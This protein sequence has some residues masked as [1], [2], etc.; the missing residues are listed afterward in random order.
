MGFE[1]SR[2]SLARFE[3]VTLRAN[4]IFDRTFPNRNQFIETV[5]ESSQTE[6]VS[7]G[8]Y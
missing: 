6:K 2:H 7:G 4:I 8:R 3:V 5:R 1:K